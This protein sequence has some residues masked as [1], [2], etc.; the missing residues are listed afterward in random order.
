MIPASEAEAETG[1]E[2]S[3]IARNR[4]G[5]RIPEE[6][7]MEAQGKLRFRFGSAWLN[8]SDS[9]KDIKHLTNTRTC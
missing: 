7:N 4:V 3:G 8:K 2:A 5:I 1:S 9:F 6:L